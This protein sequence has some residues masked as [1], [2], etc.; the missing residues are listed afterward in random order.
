MELFTAIDYADGIEASDLIEYTYSY[1]E[2][3]CE[4]PVIVSPT[5][6]AY[7]RTLQPTI[8]GTQTNPAACPFVRLQGFGNGIPD[9]DN[10]PVNADG[11]WSY[12]PTTDLYETSYYIYPQ[13]YSATGDQLSS[14]GQ[15]RYF[16]IAL[17]CQAPYIITYNA[18][19]DGRN[20]HVESQGNTNDPDCQT[21]TFYN[22]GQ[23]FGTGVPTSDSTVVSLDKTNLPNGAYSL[24]V[25]LGQGQLVSEQSSQP[26][27]FTIGSSPSVSL[28]PR[29]S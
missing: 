9:T 13:T 1:N 14:I 4:P 3:R 5:E 7:L 12:T 24:T 27:E 18:V 17:R 16:T 20:L 10:I 26:Y 11:T 2:A 15:F 19:V 23:L 25:T 8:S 22:N 21:F 28:H 6:N 29:Q